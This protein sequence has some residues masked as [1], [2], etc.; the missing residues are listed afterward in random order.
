[1]DL[2]RIPTTPQDRET[3]FA[4]ITG[5]GGRDLTLPAEVSLTP[6]LLVG[7][8]WVTAPGASIERGVLV[9]VHGG[10]FAHRMPALMNLFA[11]RLSQATGRPVLV[12]HYPL[13]PESPFPA[14]LET[15]IA[16]YQALVEHVPPSRVVLYSESS[17]GSLALGAMLGLD[18]A[19][20]PAGLI[21]VSPVTDLSLQSPS[22]DTNAVTDSGVDRRMLGF[23]VGQ[24]LQGA[25]AD[26]APQS[27]IFGNLSVLP[28]L[29][30]AVGSAEALLDDT[31]RFA[32]AA[33]A[34]GIKTQVDVYEGLPHAF[35]IA[36]LDGDQSVFLSRI[37]TWLAGIQ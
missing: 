15:V 26:R 4:A 31:L 6:P 7:E 28:P 14:A 32:E 37:V 23:L 2:H 17:G 16:A 5:L 20:R 9:Y 18:E 34:A 36:D 3:V 35:T 13:A 24:Y 1:M 10:G 12:V 25:P 30:L 11:A 29:L 22:I 21:A 27:P 8:H 33:T 19:S